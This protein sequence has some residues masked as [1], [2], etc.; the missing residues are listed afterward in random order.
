MLRKITYPDVYKIDITSGSDEAEENLAHMSH[1]Y[2]SIRQSLQCSSDLSTIF[3]V[4]SEKRQRMLGNARNTH[5]CR[6]FDK[7]KQ[8]A[9]ENKAERDLDFD[10]FVEGAPIFEE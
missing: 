7:I 3:W 1:C 4:W 8:W 5:T 9:L 2:D 10:M 6:N